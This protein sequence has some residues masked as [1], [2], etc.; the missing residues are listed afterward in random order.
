MYFLFR[1]P[2]KTGIYNLGTGRARTWNDIANAMFAALGKTARIEYIEMPEYLKPKYQYFTE[3][4]MNRLKTAGF[5]HEF[6][7]LVDSIKD[8]TQYLVKK[9]C[10]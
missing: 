7:S 6:R 1:N 9:E 3:A 5:K 4:K 2:Q 10:L 8:Y